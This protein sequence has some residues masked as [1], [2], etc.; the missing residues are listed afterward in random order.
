MKEKITYLKRNFIYI[1]FLATLSLVV[2][3]GNKTEDEYNSA[4]QKGLDELVSESYDK[5][6]VFFEMALEEKPDDKRAKALLSQ[7]EAFDTA[8][9]SLEDGNLELAIEN[10]ESVKK[11]EN[12]SEALVT[13]SND[14][15][16][17]I[18]KIN[19]LKTS[20]KET[21][22]SANS[23]FEEGKYSES[24]EQVNNLLED[25]TLGEPYYLSIKKL[26]EELKISISEKIDQ[27]AATESQSEAESKK[28][29]AL[30]SDSTDQEFADISEVQTVQEETGSTSLEQY[31]PLEIEYARILLMT[32]SVDPNSPVINVAHTPAG[33]PIADY[34]SNDSAEYP[35]VVT[36]LF[37]EFGASG[38]ITYSSNG[39][40]TITIYPVPS[41]WHQE[42]QSPEGYRA[43]TQEILDTAQT[44]YVDLGNDSDVINKIE[45]VEFIYQ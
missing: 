33:T 41:H 38:S 6:T 12:G 36:H 45:S 16:I 21:Y 17:N 14:I 35:N 43:L 42:D 37:G 40:G 24:M 31:D 30:E 34:Y 22:D 1:F 39:D 11:I 20:Y 7:T 18:K 25:E 15:L 4:I 19:T 28:N 32:G 5:A 10:A 2:G 29:V 9:E 27:I 23:L 26:S 3:C 44:V 8:L 13:K